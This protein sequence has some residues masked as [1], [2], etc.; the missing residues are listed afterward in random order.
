[1][2]NKICYTGIGARKSGEHTVAQY[3][4]VMEK[5]ATMDCPSYYKSLQCKSCK[6]DKELFKQLVKKYKK[7]PSYKLSKKFGDKLNKSYMKCHKCKNSKTRKCTLK[8]Y[9]HYSGAVP[10]KCSTTKTEG[11]IM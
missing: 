6:T 2:V 4:R 8:K 10:G 11:K 7:N 5:T 1:M 9:I 3:L